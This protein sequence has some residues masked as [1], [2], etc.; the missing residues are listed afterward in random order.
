MAHP[1][2][3]TTF[4]GVDGQTNTSLPE[5][6]A[7]GR[8]EA[9]LVSF[10]EAVRDLPQAVESAVAFQNPYSG[11]W[12]STERFNAI[13]EPERLAA[14]AQDGETDPLF[15]IPTDSYAIINPVD[16]YGPLEDVLRREELDGQSLGKVVF[17]EI[18]Q[19]RGG[20]EVHIDIMFDGVSVDL[21]GRNEPIA[22]GLSS[23]YDFFGGHAVYVEGFA[24]D[25]YCQ[26]SM[27]ALTDRQTVKHV[28]GIGSF[29]A[30]WEQLLGQLEIVANDLYAFITDAQEITLDLREVPFD[31]ETFYT[32]LS[33]RGTLQRGRP[34]TL[35][36]KLQIPSRLI[37][38]LFIPE[39]HTPSLISTL[40]RKAPRWISMSERRTTCC[41][42][43]RR[44]SSVSQTSTSAARQQRRRGDGQTGLG[45]Q[46]ALAQIERV[47]RDVREKAQE[48]EQR[49]A[50]LRERFAEVA[51]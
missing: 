21:P 28:G 12:V 35:V 48:F 6:Y 13:V 26:N 36:Q 7:R 20:G 45:S 17:G 31:V 33:F 40:G 46:V 2:T 38:G 41:S 23:G 29:E 1:E 9:E 22:M 44:R 47:E 8:D 34:A 30:W 18:R 39:R 15:N 27:R 10:A 37:C 3:T 5:W 50:T 11:E 25:S 32:L 42:T 43:R 51:E 19:Y 49:E 4:A 24:Q 16:V 14:Q